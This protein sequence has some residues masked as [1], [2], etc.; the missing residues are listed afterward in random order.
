M[1]DRPSQRLPL[2]GA[3]TGVWYGQRL[4]PESPVYNVGQYVE[5]NGA[6]DPGLFVTALR[7][8]VAESEALTARFGEDA[9]GVPYQLTWPGPAA[10]PI[11][12]TLDHT[13]QDDPVGEAVSLMRRDMATPVDP[14]R[15]PLY[16]FTLHRVGPDRTL[17]YQRVHHIALDAFGF[18]LISRR[19]A[20][21]YGAL[22]RGEEPPPSPFGGLRVVTDEEEAYRS[23]DRF[24]EDRA[25]WLDR[26]ADC[27]EPEPLSGTVPAASHAF[28]RDG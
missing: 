17:W 22:V 20:E 7:R 19:T 1:S 16:A 24:E 26:L 11:V 10:G 6:L 18:S 23:S 28:L 21:V 12:A 5:I 25:Y 13:G 27:P 8:T 2:T 3:Q 14:T 4:D 15:D 9:E